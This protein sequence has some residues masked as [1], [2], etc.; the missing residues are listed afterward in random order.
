MLGGKEEEEGR[1]E[2]GFV[3]VLW[4]GGWVPA[5]LCSFAEAWMPS[6]KGE[7]SSGLHS[8]SDCSGELGM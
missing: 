5:M 7:V 4:S 8:E 2:R 6:T 3:W 1:G